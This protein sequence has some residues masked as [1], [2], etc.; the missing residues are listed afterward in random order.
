[1]NVCVNPSG[2]ESENSKVSLNGYIIT[3]R[4]KL[5]KMLFAEICFNTKLKKEIQIVV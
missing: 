5:L 3:E 4:V 2:G 1:M